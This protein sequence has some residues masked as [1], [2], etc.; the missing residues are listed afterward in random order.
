MDLIN[1]VMR[2]LR[3]SGKKFSEEDIDA[4]FLQAAKTIKPVS[5]YFYFAADIK[6]QVMH[7]NGWG[8]GVDHR[9]VT[10]EIGRRWKEKEE[11]EKITWINK[12]ADEKKR[13]EGFIEYVKNISE[14]RKK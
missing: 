3:K 2:K 8:Q 7:E 14:K 13:L 5:A 10:G 1:I 9:I 6:D 11:T 12:A 4:N